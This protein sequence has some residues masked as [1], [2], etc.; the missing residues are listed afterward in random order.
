M[1]EDRTRAYRRAKLALLKRRVASYY[2]GYAR[3][4]AHHIGML[5]R[6]RTL[7]SGPC[8]G[9]PRRHTGERTVQ[10]RRAAS[11]DYL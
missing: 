10:E 8:C 6:T 11:A 4:N 9:N 3:G 2:G 1:T 5:A 7:C